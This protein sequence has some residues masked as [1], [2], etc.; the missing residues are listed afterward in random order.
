[1]G[2]LARTAA[3]RIHVMTNITETGFVA[4]AEGILTDMV[5]L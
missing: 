5:Y 4:T 1:M 2:I 3:M